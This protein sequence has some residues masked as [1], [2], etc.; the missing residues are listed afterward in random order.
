MIDIT[1]W[2]AID[3]ITRPLS[4]RIN[5]LPGRWYTVRSRSLLA[6]LFDLVTE[7]VGRQTGASVA[8][9]RPLIVA[10]AYDLTNAIDRQAA[11]WARSLFLSDWPPLDRLLR[12]VAAQATVVA[13]P[14]ESDI[15]RTATGWRTQIET[16]LG[17]APTRWSI[18][19]LPCP[20]C[21][22][23]VWLD[24]RPGDGTY[25]MP[26]VEV[27]ARPR[28]GATK[29]DTEDLWLYRHCR[30]CGAHGWLTYTTQTPEV[31]A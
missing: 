11:R 10:E 27:E 21:R 15:I 12:R 24:V 13:H 25:R 28:P 2:Q 18:R 9:S 29:D 20:D 22:A 30:A 5:Y 26:A 19:D 7:P 14:L 3:S 1:A 16:M 4:K 23:M 17:A 8:R 6:Q 31:A